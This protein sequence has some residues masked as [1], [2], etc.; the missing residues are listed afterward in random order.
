MSVVNEIEQ[1]QVGQNWSPSYEWKIVLLLT[2]GF[3]LVGLDRQIIAPLFPSMMKD[4]NLTYQDLGNLIGILGITWGLFSIVAG[5]LSDKLGR[6]ALIVPA[7]L[8][9]S[10]MAGFAGMAGGITALLVLRACMGVF[11]GAYTPTSFATIAEGSKPSRLGLNQGIEQSAFPLIGLGLGPI[12]AT[13][14]L[15]VVPSWRW[16]FAVVALPGLILGIALWFVI[17]EPKKFQATPTQQERPKIPLRQLFKHRNVPLGM[18][19]LFCNMSGVFVIGAMIPVYLTD[20][21]K[22]SNQQ[23]GFVASAIGFGGFLGQ[24]VLPG[25]SDVLGRKTV[26]LLS[27]IGAA[28]FISLFANAG[29][30]NLTVLFILLFMTCFFCFANLGIITGP[31]AVEAAPVGAIATVAGIIIGAGEVF[32]GGVVPA[33]AGGIAQKF[34]LQHTLT[35]AL[36]GFIGGLLTTL[37]LKET[38]P[39]KVSTQDSPTITN[40]IV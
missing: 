12:I 4:L 11:E 15:L 35:V 20:Y 29:Q 37:F 9:F 5:G 36:V 13:Q 28:V 10:L 38:A 17:K 39:C 8:G 32:G 33:I 16:V 7:V 19:A 1:S 3:G 24:V 25:L 26:L 27:F 21:I 18:F 6:R 23:M 30:S 22:L 40:P 14:L 2:C 34:G 31:I